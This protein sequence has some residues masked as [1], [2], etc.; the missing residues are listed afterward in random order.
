MVLQF[1]IHLSQMNTTMKRKILSM[2]E[3]TD[4]EVELLPGD[5]FVGKG[6]EAMRFEVIMASIMKIRQHTSVVIQQMAMLLKIQ[7]F[8]LQCLEQSELN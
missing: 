2:V 6:G 4:A 1:I 3:M 7:V 5:R 8:L